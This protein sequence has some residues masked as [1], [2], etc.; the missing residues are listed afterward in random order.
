LAAAVPLRRF[1]KLL[2]HKEKRAN[3]VHV[4]NIAR[5]PLNYQMRIAS[6]RPAIILAH[7]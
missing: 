3:E 7:Q 4:L 6:R 5:A 2:L 1:A